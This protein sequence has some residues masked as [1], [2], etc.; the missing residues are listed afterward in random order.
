MSRLWVSAGLLGCKMSR[1]QLKRD[2]FLITTLKSSCFALRTKQGLLECC[3]VRRS[4]NCRVEQKLAMKRVTISQNHIVLC[5]RHVSWKECSMSQGH[6]GCEAVEPNL[7]GPSPPHT[8]FFFLPSFEIDTVLWSFL[9]ETRITK[10]RFFT[11]I[12]TM[13]WA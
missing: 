11:L 5:F 8:F 13:V 3:H 4:R 6:C 1:H 2:V 7:E 9:V 10:N 12:K